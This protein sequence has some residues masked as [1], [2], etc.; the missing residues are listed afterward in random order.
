MRKPLAT[1]VASLV[2]LAPLT[3]AWGQKPETPDTPRPG[4][5]GPNPGASNVPAGGWQFV[6]V[7][8]NYYSHMTGQLIGYI[9]TWRN[10]ATG[11]DAH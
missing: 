5:T 11:D 4:P 3:G 9:E 1:I 10:T 6:S 2:L 8:E 7:T